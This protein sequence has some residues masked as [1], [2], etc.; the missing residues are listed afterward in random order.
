MT[1]LRCAAKLHG[2][3]SANL[4]EIKCNSVFCGAQ[5]GVVVL[6]QFSTVT[7]DLLATLVYR[8]PQSVER[9]ATNHGDPRNSDS[10]RHS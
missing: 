2:H 5:Q 1:E 10:V 7:G 9:S 6:H 4:V 8:Q 3:L